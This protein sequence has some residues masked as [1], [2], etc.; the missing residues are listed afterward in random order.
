MHRG[1]SRPL[2]GPGPVAAAAGGAGRRRGD[3]AAEPGAVARG[4]VPGPLRR[5]RSCR[6]QETR[7][8]RCRL[9]GAAARG[10]TSRAGRSRGDMRRSPALTAARR[11]GPRCSGATSSASSSPRRPQLHAGSTRPRPQRTRLAAAFGSNN[12]TSA[13]FGP[14]PQLQTVAGFTVFKIFMTLMHP[15]GRVGPVDQH[16]AAAR[17]GGHAGG[18]SSCS[19][20]RP[21][22]GAPPSR[23]S[24][25]W[26]VGVGRPVGGHRPH[27]RGHRRSAQRRYQPGAWPVLRPGPGGQ[28]GHVPRPSA[29]SPASWRRP[30]DRRPPYAAAFLGVSLRGADG[31]RRRHRPPRAHLGVAARVGRR[32][33]AP[34]L[35]PAAGPAPDRRLHRRRRC[36]ASV[37]LAGL[38]DVGAGHHRPTGPGRARMCGCSPGPSA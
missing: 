9:D 2:P 27:H 22:G 7:W 23:R 19:P 18:G 3:A 21:P 25:A 15:R 29:H 8:P 33:P 32:A 30:G 1:P 24:P 14:A 35:A 28:R 6:R 12:A 37:H 34:D 10:R 31:G 36:L 11:S 26:P 17:R 20:A 16:P 13:L 4:A 38:R 5:D